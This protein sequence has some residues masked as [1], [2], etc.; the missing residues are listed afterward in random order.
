MS[1]ACLFDMIIDDKTNVQTIIPGLKRT[2]IS[3]SIHE[4]KDNITININLK[5]EGDLKKIFPFLSAEVNK[6]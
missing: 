6:I 4:S 2:K 1:S 5:K 3:N